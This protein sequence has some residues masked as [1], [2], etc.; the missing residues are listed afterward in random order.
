MSTHISAS[1][2]EMNLPFWDANF[3]VKQ[4]SDIVFNTSVFFVPVYIDVVLPLLLNL[5]FL[6]PFL[7]SNE[8]SDK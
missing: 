4:E 5:Q 2:L 3:N 7:I 8:R 1:L 6:F